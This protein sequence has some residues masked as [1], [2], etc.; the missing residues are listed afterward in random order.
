MGMRLRDALKSGAT[1]VGDGGMGTELQLAGLEPGGCGDAWNLTHPEDVQ[2]IHRRYVNAG[3]QIILTNTFGTNRFLLSR[4]ALEDRVA[5]VARAATVNARAAAGTQILVLGD[6]GPCGGFLE[7]LGEI[8]AAELRATWR[9]AITEMLEEGVDG[10]LFETM[11]SLDEILLGIRVAREL[12]APVVAA[13]MAYDAVRG[14][15]F[16][17]MMGVSPAQGA[18]ACVDT[19]ADVVGANCGRAEPED[20]VAIAR[21]LRAATDVPLIIQPNAGQPTLAGATIVYPRDAASLAPALVTLT[22]HAA[23]VGGC[24]GTTPAHMLAFSQA[25]RS[26]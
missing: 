5:D 19:G 13:S 20:F 16:R 4:Y 21:E 22:R 9:L 14:G 10:I 2:S 12:G 1:L 11:S 18:R 25:L 24:C 8:S 3:A 7:P 17:T 26:H 23:I 15:G 6:I